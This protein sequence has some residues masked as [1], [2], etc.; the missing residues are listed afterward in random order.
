M[1]HTQSP[2]GRG[3]ASAIALT[4]RMSGAYLK[5]PPAFCCVGRLALALARL[6]QRPKAINRG[7]LKQNDLVF[8]CKHTLAKL[9][10]TNLKQ[11]LNAGSVSF[12]LI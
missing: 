6:A 1:G 2:V 10:N 7:A 9:S 5:R 4:L 3:L 11:S 12:N 8:A